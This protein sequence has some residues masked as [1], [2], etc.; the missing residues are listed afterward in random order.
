MAFF[1]GQ[2]T[3]SIDNKGR[4]NIPAKMRK[5]LSPEA[6]D[7]FAITRGLDRCITAYPIDEWKKYEEKFANLNQYDEKNRYFLRM[8]LM[9]SEEVTLD[10]Q[11]RISLPRKLLEF[12]GIE[13]KVMI[14]GMGD[15]IEFWNPDE[16][17]NYLN[18][19]NE[20]YEKVAE[21]VFSDSMK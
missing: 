6:N 1:K 19:F 12:A 7:T 9:W 16:F 11:Q 8:L 15:H 3:Y 17:E 10:A 21:Q 4:V 13:S 14:V 5:S 18:R 2:E 20:P